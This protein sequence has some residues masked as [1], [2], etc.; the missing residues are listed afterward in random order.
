MRSICGRIIFA[1]SDHDRI[2][3]FVDVEHD[4]RKNRIGWFNGLAAILIAAASTMACNADLSSRGGIQSGRG[5][6]A[7][8]QRGPLVRAGPA[9]FRLRREDEERFEVALQRHLPEVAFSEHLRVTV[10]GWRRSGW[11]D[12]RRLYPCRAACQ[13]TGRGS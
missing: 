5:P 10:S 13:L 4:G 6:V 7:R 12:A 2:I 8:F 9:R 1:A 3:G 11:L